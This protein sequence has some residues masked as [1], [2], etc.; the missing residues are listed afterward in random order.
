M[1]AAVTQTELISDD[2]R[3]ETESAGIVADLKEFLKSSREM[4][5]LLTTGQAAAVLNVAPGSVRS[6]V[7][8]GR[9]SS[10]RV[11]GI[12]MVAAPEVLAFH[13]QR[14]SEGLSVGG[15]G[16]KAASIRDMAR[17]AWND[18]NPLGE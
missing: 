12:V 4:G 18:I 8:R 3:R 6:W 10:T 5:G 7:L 16:H 2:P 9:L 15:R 14:L 11:L 17:E 13:R 1:I